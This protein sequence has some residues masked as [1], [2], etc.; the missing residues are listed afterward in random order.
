MKNSTALLALLLASQFVFSQKNDLPEIIEF[1]VTPTSALNFSKPTILLGVEI[2]PNEKLGFQVEYGFPL[3]PIKFEFNQRD[4]RYYIY[5]KIKSELK[6]YTFRKSGFADY[7]SLGL[8][9]TP[10]SY[11]SPSGAIQ[12]EDGRVFSY[13]AGRLRVDET[14]GFLNYGGKAWL[15]D[16]FFIEYYIGG[17]LKRAH[18]KMVR[19]QNA[20][21]LSMA[22][23]DS[24]A[25]ALLDFNYDDSEGWHTLL[26]ADFGLKL[27]LSF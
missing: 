1:K 9:H 13:S 18:V 8:L 22:N 26:F 2:F 12:L 5:Q 19:M 3:A 21:L 10:Q 17:G 20:V 7:L 24:L 11:T 6:Y 16:H 4:H 23:R 15:T 14:S 25:F 27:G